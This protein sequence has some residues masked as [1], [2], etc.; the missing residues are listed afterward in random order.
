M[1]LK[2]Q[3][4]VTFFSWC[5]FH[6]RDPTFKSDNNVSPIDLSNTPNMASPIKRKAPE[7]KARS[8]QSS[9]KRQRIAGGVG[10]VADIPSDEDLGDDNEG[11]DAV[12]ELEEAEDE[13]DEYGSSK[14]EEEGEDSDADSETSAADHDVDDD[15]DDNSH[16]GQKKLKKRNDPSVFAN[17]ISKILASRI[18][19]APESSKLDSTKPTRSVDPVLARSKSAVAATQVISHSR[20]EEKARQKIREEK[21]SR[22]NKGRISDVLG[23]SDP[24]VS[25]TE[26]LE[27]EKR[28]KKIA[29]RG[30]V[31]LF[32][33][34]RNT[35]RLA[36]V[37]QKEGEGI[38]AGEVGMIGPGLS[39]DEKEE[40]VSEMSKKG[41]LELIAG[42]GKK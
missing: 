1:R 11:S 2:F 24:T 9:T 30:V 41:F 23:L 31:M 6:C 21:R 28:Y 8:S 19:D 12:E 32:N 22:K 33:A 20:L 10:G 42:G 40:R 35:Q 7:G 5:F 25:T 14:L 16:P 38:G 36:E 27:R 34:I 15:D 13:D 17:S 4:H 3:T 29:Q 26:I 18:T 39:R 37:V